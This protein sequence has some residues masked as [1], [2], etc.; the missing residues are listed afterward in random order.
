MVNEIV[1]ARG[2]GAMYD[3]KSTRTWKLVDTSPESVIPSAGMSELF[4]TPQHHHRHL[5]GHRCRG[6]DLGHSGKDHLRL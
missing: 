4:H 1:Y 2:T 6:A 3:V 5:P